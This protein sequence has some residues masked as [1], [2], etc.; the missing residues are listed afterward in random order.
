M[1]PTMPGLIMTQI[2]ETVFDSRSSADPILHGQSGLL[3]ADV[4]KAAEL[5]TLM[6]GVHEMEK[7]NCENLCVDS[8]DGDA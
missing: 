6:A 4:A 8:N 5:N 7:A 1:H 3:H 2:Q